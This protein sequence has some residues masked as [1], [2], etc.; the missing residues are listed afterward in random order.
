MC[1]HE[2]MCLMAKRPL[3]TKIV[4]QIP[5]D[6]DDDDDNDNDVYMPV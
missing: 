3:L 1:L 5:H 6:D 2:C 4:L